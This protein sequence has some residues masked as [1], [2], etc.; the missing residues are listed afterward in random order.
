MS[1]ESTRNPTIA[2]LE[3]TTP[4]IEEDRLAVVR[5][6]LPEMLPLVQPALYRQ[7]IYCLL[8]PCHEAIFFSGHICL[9]ADPCYSHRSIHLPNGRN[10]VHIGAL[11]VENSIGGRRTW[12][13]IEGLSVERNRSCSAHIVPTVPNTRAA[14]LN[15]LIDFMASLAHNKCNV[16]SRLRIICSWIIMCCQ[17][18]GWRNL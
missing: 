16:S 14:L 6:A 11:L 5:L 2:L 4:I 12:Y 13:P 10:R 8:V 9:V 7:A 3:I 15:M 18:N 1:Q 17:S